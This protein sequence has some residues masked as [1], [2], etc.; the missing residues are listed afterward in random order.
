MEQKSV[1]QQKEEIQK[2]YSSDIK[3][4]IRE[5]YAPCTGRDFELTL[6]VEMLKA[7]IYAD[8]EIMATEMQIKEALIVTNFNLKKVGDKRIAYAR[9]IASFN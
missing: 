8:L 7:D 9:K 3:Y 2:D 4:Y 6:T 5:R 1:A